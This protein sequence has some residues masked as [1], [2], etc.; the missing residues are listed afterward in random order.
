MRLVVVT[1]RQTVGCH[2]SVRYRGM[3]ATLYI[4]IN[5]SSGAS[6][7]SLKSRVAEALGQLWGSLIIKT[8][9]GAPSPS[10]T[11]FQ[12]V[13]FGCGEHLHVHISKAYNIA[14]LIR[15]C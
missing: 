11:G 10:L 5:G 3:V 7:V 15:I 13:Y 4:Q 12:A 14:Q 2:G 8:A 1:C 9:H 6:K